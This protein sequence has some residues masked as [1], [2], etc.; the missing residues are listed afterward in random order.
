MGHVTTPLGELIRRYRNQVNMTLAQLESIINVS[1]GSLSKIETGETKKPDFKILEAI[2]SVLNI[3][4]REYVEQYIQVEHR[5]ESLM[6]ILELA[7]TTSE[8]A[9]IAPQI[10]AKYLETEKRDSIELVESLYIVTASIKEPPIR[11]DL[12]NS[13]IDYSRSHGIMPYIAQGM[14]QKYMIERNDFSKL[15]Y[16]YQLGRSILS[17]ANFLNEKE[18]LILYYAL[19]V[20][21]V[22]LSKY[23]EAIELS[24]YVT[25]NDVTKSK[26]KA[27][28]TLNICNSYFCLGKYED[29]KTY[30]DEYAKFPYDFIEDN[31]KVMLS[32]IN[33][34][35]V[36]LDLG[37]QQFEQYLLNPSEYNL[38][39]VVVQLMDFYSIKKDSNAARQL[40][41]YEEQMKMSLQD[42]Y[43]TPE[44]RA[45]LAYY[46]RLKG[47]LLLADKDFKHALDCYKMSTIEYAG[48][49]HFGKA[50]DGISLITKA[51]VDDNTHLEIESI[52]ELNQMVIQIRDEI[53]EEGDGL[54]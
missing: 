14:Y 48:I 37:I 17:Y 16:T 26:L 50:F 53:N 23:D 2:A 29:S 15:K 52:M 19:G 4:F 44:K 31:V 51:I 41:K 27:D 6:A 25:H 21:A 42:I 20:H 33:G 10:A 5:A 32:G 3:P 36:S 18:R 46:Y 13:I 35:T 39:Y 54:I 30:L 45:K 34:K 40:F 22:S 8:H 47:D 7:I 49:S 28:A 12:Y 11:L 9:S 1:K 24:K 43:T 38:T